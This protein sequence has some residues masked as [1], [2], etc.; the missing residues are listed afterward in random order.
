MERARRT[1]ARGGG[2]SSGTDGLG[3][4]ARFEVNWWGLRLPEEALSTAVR[5]V[6]ALGDGGHGGIMAGGAELAAPVESRLQGTI[7]AGKREGRRRSS[8]RC[9]R[10]G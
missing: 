1:R 8:Q 3:A 2:Q 7:E 9:R 4:T 5:S 6:V 10:D